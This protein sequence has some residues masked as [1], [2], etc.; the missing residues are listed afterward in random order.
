MVFETKTEAVE[1]DR[2]DEN[3]PNEGNTGVV[4]K[5]K[6]VARKKK[7]TGQ[8]MAGVNGNLK[9]LE[10]IYTTKQNADSAAKKAWNRIL[11]VCDIIRE[12]SERP[13]KPEEATSK[14]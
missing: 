11:E 13:W 6:D 10:H 9:M 4:A 7:K 1:A 5:C 2:E 12:N 8:E 14:V 3:D